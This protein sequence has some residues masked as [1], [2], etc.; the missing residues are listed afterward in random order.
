MKKINHPLLLMLMSFGGRFLLLI[1]FLIGINIF[2]QKKIKLYDYDEKDSVIYT[3]KD[4]LIQKCVVDKYQIDDAP[5]KREGILDSNSRKYKVLNRMIAS[6]IKA[7]YILIPQKTM[8]LDSTYIYDLPFKKGKFYRVSQGYN[9]KYSHKNTYAVDFDMIEGTEVYAAREGKVILVKQDSN[10]GCAHI[11]CVK[12]ANFVHV[13]HPDGTMGEYVHFKQFGVQV[14]LGDNIKK[15]D[16]I[17]YSGSTGFSSGPHLHF[18]CFSG[19][20]SNKT[21]KTL[22][23]VNDGKK[24]VYLVEGK[25]YSKNY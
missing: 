1:L 22:F 7:G 13:F 11:K 18:N 2:S 21:I 9:G 8:P 5:C 25:N 24:T 4:S 15:G 6:N 17:G 23:R 20:G 16:L 12:Y 14:K 10:I 19:L 3:L